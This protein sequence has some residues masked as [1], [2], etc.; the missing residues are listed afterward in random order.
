MTGSG[1]P[2]GARNPNHVLVS[3]SLKPDSATVGVSGKSAH[4]PAGIAA[5][6]TALAEEFP[7]KRPTL[8]LGMLSD[9]DWR[10]MAT[11]LVPLASRVV[12]APVANERTVSAEDL[13]AACVATGAGRPVKAAASAAAALKL[14]AADPFVVVT[15]SLYF[16]GEVMEALGIQSARDDER[17]LNEWSPIRTE[18][19]DTATDI[20]Q[21]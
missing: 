10:A 14:V 6:R 7:G 3:K 8:V 5:L 21:T 2:A 15:G 16:I 12:T 1:V 4:N 19:S 13:R 18:V 9:K 11:S 17:R 20:A